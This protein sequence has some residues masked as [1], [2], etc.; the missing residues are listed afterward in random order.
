[1]C[2]LEQQQNDDGLMSRLQPRLVSTVKYSL[3]D[4][5]GQG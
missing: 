5:M 1:M 4:N 3:A 2:P